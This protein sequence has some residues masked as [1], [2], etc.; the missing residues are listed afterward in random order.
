MK[1]NP[2]RRFDDSVALVVV[3][4]Q[5]SEGPAVAFVLI[6]KGNIVGYLDMTDFEEEYYVV[7]YSA[8]E[9]GLGPLLYESAL[10]WGRKNSVKIS[11]GSASVEAEALWRKFYERQDVFKQEVRHDD[12]P[13]WLRS[14]YWKTEP[15]EGYAEALERGGR[16]QQRNEDLRQAGHQ[17]Y[18][19]MT[20]QTYRKLKARLL[21]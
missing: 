15:L 7:D 21:R 11:P 19:E 14:V 18:L 5:T 4:H 2:A 16:V 17:F 13:V 12:D 10:E 1:R 6:E 9:H 20:G 8:A 3:P